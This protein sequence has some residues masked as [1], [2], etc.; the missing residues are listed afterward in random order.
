MSPWL[1]PGA[2]LLLPIALTFSIA[3]PLFRGREAKQ[4]TLW[5][6]Y[7]GL[8]RFILAITVAGWWILWDLGG[9]SE[10]APKFVRAWSQTLETS[11][12]EGL[13]FWVPPVVSLAILLILW[14]TF[15]RAFLKLRWT[16]IDLMRRAWWRLVSFVIPLLM[17]ATGFD[18]IFAGRFRGVAWLLSAGVVSKVGTGFLRHAEGVKFNKLKSGELRSRALKMANRMGATLSRVYIVPAGK[19][20]LTNAYGMSNAIGL[21]DSLGRYLSKGQIDFVI[22]H[23]LG[24]VQLRHGRKHLLVVIAIFSIMGLVFFRLSQHVLSFQPLVQLVVVL[25]PLIAIYYFSRRFEYSADRAAVEFTGDPETAIRALA[26]LHKVHEVPARCDRF[27]ELFATH[28]ALARR[29]E[30]IANLRQ[31]PAER[32]SNILEDV[33]L[34][35]CAARRV[36]TV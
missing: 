20:H 21:T 5:A 3:W 4:G 14:Y 1:V 28:P 34:S 23:E 16:I 33:G 17:V 15:D 30:A 7:R 27:T 12:G 2:I 32:L 36:S 29:V 8:G 11:S 26:N 35:E 13:L 31:I 25:A 6:V 10:L 19:G 18:A 22:A 9:H 24:H